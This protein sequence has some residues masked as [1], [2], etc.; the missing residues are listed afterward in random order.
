MPIKDLSVWEKLVFTAIGWHYGCMMQPMF[1]RLF[2]Y[3]VGLIT[4]PLGAAFLPHYMVWP[5][6]GPPIPKRFKN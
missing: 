4:I 6:G 3:P 2:A 1:I 5:N